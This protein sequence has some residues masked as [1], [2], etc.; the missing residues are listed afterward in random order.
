MW[1]TH[2]HLQS[3]CRSPSALRAVGLENIRIPIKNA[4]I[5]FARTPFSIEGPNFEDDFKKF[6][7]GRSDVFL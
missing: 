1:E 3:R 6:I 4:K 7:I 5:V 2:T